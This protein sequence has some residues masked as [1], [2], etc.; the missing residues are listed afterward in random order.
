MATRH[1]REYSVSL[2]G[3]RVLSCCSMVAQKSG[4]SPYGNG[5]REVR[6]MQEHCAG[7]QYAS[8]TDLV[9][10]SNVRLA[11]GSTTVAASRCSSIVAAVRDEHDLDVDETWERLACEAVDAVD[12]ALQAERDDEFTQDDTIG[13]PSDTESSDEGSSKLTDDRDAHRERA[14][15]IS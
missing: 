15:S 14:I 2:F 11:Q 7:A 12:R 8:T 3:Y 6:Y 13:F 4:V 5:H 10:V 9:T 1:R